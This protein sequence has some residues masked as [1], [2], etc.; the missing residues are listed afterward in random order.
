VPPLFPELSWQEVEGKDTLIDQGAM[1]YVSSDDGQYFA[2]AAILEGKEWYAEKKNMDVDSYSDLIKNFT[3]Y[4]YE[5]V[6][7]IGW[8]GTIKVPGYR[9]QAITADGPT[10]SRWGFV[11]AKG[12]FFR[13]VIFHEERWRSKNGDWVNA[14]ECPCSLEYSVF[15]TP[16]LTLK[17]ILAKAEIE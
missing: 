11:G 3:Q 5:K 8:D 16:K 10:G 2:N 7:A 9:L 15:V 13:I 6:Q 14:G 4:S 12:G 17:D 1:L